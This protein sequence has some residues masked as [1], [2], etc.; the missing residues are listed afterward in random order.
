MRG[1]PLRRAPRTAAEALRRLVAGNEA[2][3]GIAEKGARG[4]RV[5][6]QLDP[7]ELGFGSAP[8]VAPQ[9]RPFAAVLGC[10]DARVPVEMVFQQ[11]SNDLFV[12]RVAGNGI[13]VGGL[14]TLRYAAA[15]FADSLR[16]VVVLGHSQCG[17]VSAAVDAFLRPRELPAA[18]ERLPA[19]L[20][21]RRPSSSR[22]AP[23]ASRSSRCTGRASSR[24]RGTAPRSSR[25]R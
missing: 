24:G 3:A 17:A 19:A 4:E 14:G 18:R 1:G 15:H 25:P 2:F 5:V 7:G 21:G 20:A 9:Q 10:A 23:R 16:L 6:V 12:V 11:R 8:G 22:C 13:G